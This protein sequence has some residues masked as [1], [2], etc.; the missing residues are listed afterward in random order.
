MKQKITSADLAEAL[1]SV[2]EKW[3]ELALEPIAKREKQ[4]FVGY[5]L[6]KL[7]GVKYIWVF[8]VIFILINSFVAFMTAGNSPAASEPSALIADFFAE[9]ENNPDELNA[10]HDKILAFNAEQNRLF[11]EAMAAGNLD[12]ERETLPDVYST[13]ENYSDQRLFSKLFDAINAAAE[14]PGV[15]QRVID[16]AYS[17]L[18]EFAQM[19]IAPDSFTYKYQL[20]VIRLYES[21]RDNVHP[22]VVYTRGWSE[23]FDYTIVDLFVFLLLMMSCSV[24]FAE[25]K[26]TGILPMIRVSRNG[27][28]RTAAAKILAALCFT[29][30]VTLTFT[31]TTFAVFGLKLGYSS[32]TNVL[33]SLGEFTLSPY[34]MTIGGYFAAT[35]GVKL[36]TFSLFTLVILAFATIFYNYIMIWLCGLGFFGLN[37][38][39]YA[40]KY[41]DSSNPLKNLNLVATAAVNPIFTRYRAV[42]LFG[43]V[44]GYL[45]FMLVFFGILAVGCGVFTVIRFAKGGE[46]RP[47]FIDPVGCA[48]RE[49]TGRVSNSLRKIKLPELR[50]NYSMSLFSAE[51]YKTLISSRFIIVVALL[52]AVKCGYSISTNSPARSYADSVYKEYMTSLEGELTDEK[53]DYLAAEREMINSTLEKQQPMQQAYINDEITFD[54]YRAYLTDYNYAF[55]RSEL[56]KVIENHAAYLERIEAESGQKGWFAYD[57]GWKKLYSGDA[58]LF[59]YTSILLLLTGSFASEYLS[60]S[61]S[62]GFSQILRAT[63]NG[64]DR[65]FFAKLISAGTISAVLTILFNAVDLAVIFAGYDMPSADAPLVSIELFGSVRSGITIGGYLAVFLMLRLAASLI[66]SM[67]VC[68]LS[69]LLCRYVPVLG[70]VAVLTLLPGLFAYFGLAA[71]DKVSFLNLLAGTPLF[72]ESA[73][74]SLFGSGWSMLAVWIAAAGCAVIAM[75]VPAKKMFVR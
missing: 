7:L 50:R 60:R 19:G 74:C 31:A 62:G 57:T 18:D 34:E 56:L 70:S 54:E 55:S 71:A 47:G 28:A 27:R 22:D 39:L 42:N 63:R 66:M 25:E 15:M 67:L 29:W 36:L 1:G 69:E 44:A 61:S 4:R 65:T 59:L 17:N 48:L 5:E 64:R 26:Q 3:Y 20:R 52:L 51:V 72:L 10:Y 75:L 16:R 33:Q 23:Y 40:L 46:L 38:L 35:V 53:L 73:K 68:A 13:D 37:F 45:P 21:V 24:I 32:P 11:S 9:Y 6:Q 12:F 2:D 14:Y 8:L 30:F 58:D 41:P 49:I 43:N